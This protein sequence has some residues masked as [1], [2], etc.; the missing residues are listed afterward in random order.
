MVKTCEQITLFLFTKNKI[1]VKN[2]LF[3]VLN[4]ENKW[5]FYRFPL[6]HMWRLQKYTLMEYLHPI[7]P[8]MLHLENMQESLKKGKY[9]IK[10]SANYVK[11]RYLKSRTLPSFWISCMIILI[12]VRG[13]R[14]VKITPSQMLLIVYSVTFSLFAIFGIRKRI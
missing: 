12:A 6:K 13:C 8:D 9:D 4:W 7:M 5:S 10:Y 1:S 14:L 2:L 3:L 11:K